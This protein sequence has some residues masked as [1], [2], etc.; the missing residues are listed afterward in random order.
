[1]PRTQAA[2]SSYRINK[3]C[4][5]FGPALG[6][7]KGIRAFF[8]PHH[9]WAEID[10]EG[11]AVGFIKGK[12]LPALLGGEIFRHHFIFDHLVGDHLPRAN[13]ITHIF[14]NYAAI[15]AT[16]IK[17]WFRGFFTRGKAPKVFVLEVNPYVNGIIA[18]LSLKRIFSLNF[19]HTFTL[20]T[21]IRQCRGA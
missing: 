17:K 20:R 8:L 5:L 7:D 11:V 15:L 3:P 1:M 6:A 4:P 16:I 2:R 9:A 18:Q 12:T 13:L 19:G 21:Q 10:P 14:R